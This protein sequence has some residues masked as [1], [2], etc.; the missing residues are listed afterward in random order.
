MVAFARAVR[1]AEL[2]QG[3]KKR[4]VA[5]TVRD[6]IAYISQASNEALIDNQRRDPDGS[7]SF[8]LEHT[9][10]VNAKKD[11]DKKQQLSIPIIVL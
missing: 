1:Q 4:L 7:L 3:S 2:F 8:L 6:A 10:N 9:F 5:A 11:T